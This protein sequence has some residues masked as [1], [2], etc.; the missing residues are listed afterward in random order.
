MGYHYILLWRDYVR[1]TTVHLWLESRVCFYV[2]YRNICRYSYSVIENK[3]FLIYA[4]AKLKF[5]W[6]SLFPTFLKCAAAAAAAQSRNVLRIMSVFSNS[7][8]RSV[9]CRNLNN[10]TL[11][12]TYVLAHSQST[13]RLNINFLPCNKWWKM[14]NESSIYCT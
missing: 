4:K 5:I 2:Y 14:Y 6:F 13:I 12:P 8:L 10:A 9:P 11:P 3:Q 1:C 7:K